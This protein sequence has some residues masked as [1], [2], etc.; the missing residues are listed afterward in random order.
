[1]ASK[2]LRGFSMLGKTSVY[3]SYLLWYS[4]S[5]KKMHN[6]KSRHNTIKHFLL[7]EI[8]SINYVKSK[9]NIVDSLTKNLLREL[10]YD[11]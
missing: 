2:F 5:N 6:D 4:V 10:M 1:M 7:N 3:Y 8:I 9:Q 11:S